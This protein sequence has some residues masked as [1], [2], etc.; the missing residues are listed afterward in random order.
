MNLTKPTGVMAVLHPQGIN[1]MDY[2][3]KEWTNAQNA[4]E[5]EHVYKCQMYNGGTTYKLYK[6]SVANL[7]RKRTGLKIERVKN[8]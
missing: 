1:N 7:V 2:I 5:K 8:K 3:D 4:N 6:P